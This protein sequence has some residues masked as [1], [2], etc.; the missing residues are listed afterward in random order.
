M[1]YVLLLI[2]QM[3]VDHRWRFAHSSRSKNYQASLV[4]KMQNHALGLRFVIHISGNYSSSSIGLTHRTILSGGGKFYGK[5]CRDFN[6]NMNIIGW[7]SN[8]LTD[9]SSFGV[10]WTTHNIGNSL[11]ILF[12]KNQRYQIVFTDWFHHFF[13]FWIRRWFSQ[14]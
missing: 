13:W 14:F 5:I 8:A 3:C 1:Q 11:H 2:D 10:E 12:N 4:Q 6:K 9:I 7:N